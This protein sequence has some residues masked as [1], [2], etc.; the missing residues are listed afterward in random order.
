M[1]NFHCHCGRFVGN[2]KAKL[3]ADNEITKVTGVCKKHGVVDV[4]D[5]EWC[6]EDFFPEEGLIT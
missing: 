4:T 5:Q 3:T 6:Y 2:I 1:N